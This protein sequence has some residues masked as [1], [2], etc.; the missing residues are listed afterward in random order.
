MIRLKKGRLALLPLCWSLGMAS[1]G[2]ASHTLPQSNGTAAPAPEQ[3]AACVQ[4]AKEQ[5]FK[6]LAGLARYAP[7]NAVLQAP[8]PSQRRVVFMGDSI[9]E[10]WSKLDPDFFAREDFVNRGISAQTTV[11]ML[12]RFRADVIDL[13]PA[14]VHIMAGTNDLAGNTGP[15][16]LPGIEA[17]IASMAD[18]ARANGIRVVLASVLPAAEFPWRPGLNPGPKIVALNEWQRQYSQAHHLGYVDYY[19]AMNDG[20]LGMRAALSSDGVHPTKEGYR[21][22]D[23]VAASAI[24]AAQHSSLQS[25]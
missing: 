3:R 15:M 6:D 13:K 21:I 17:N 25:P 2:T 10:F 1:L 12:L 5:V 20:K 18:L 23:A 14:V 4:E 19:A 8:R 9:T 22:M 24:D 7:D 16:D 11:Q